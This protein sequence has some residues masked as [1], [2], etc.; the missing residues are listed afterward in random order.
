MLRKSVLFFFHF[1]ALTGYTQ[2]PSEALVDVANEIV[3]LN[4]GYSIRLIGASARARGEKIEAYKLML[5]FPDGTENVVWNPPAT[6]P[7]NN[8][9]S[10][11]NATNDITL[12]HPQS[13]IVKNGTLGVI[14][15]KKTWNTDTWWLRW[16]LKEKRMINMVRFFSQYGG[17]YRFIDER[18]ISTNEGEVTIDDQGRVFRNGKRYPR[19][20]F[21]YEGQRETTYWP[22]DQGGKIEV[23]ENAQV[24]PFVARPAARNEPPP[25]PPAKADGN[26]LPPPQ[27]Q[28]PAALPP[29]ALLVAQAPAVTAENSAPVWPW[30]VGIAAL[31][32][33]AWLVL[34]RRALPPS[35]R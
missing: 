28:P 22:M 18:T 27:D 33:V 8:A 16:D 32:V 30:L 5:R 34:K 6:E 23:T 2:N 3:F 19:S 35:C 21:V 4:D 9:I 11:P 29:P 13:G 20:H 1:V 15:A 26:V 12:F 10:S 17:K 14:I 25:N 24:W 31:A 7:H